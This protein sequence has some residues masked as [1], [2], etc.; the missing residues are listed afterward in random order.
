M[1]V[2]A[3]VWPCVLHLLELDFP[4]RITLGSPR[5]LS[6]ATGWRGGS[7]GTGL[8]ERVLAHVFGAA[9][10]LLLRAGRL[11]W[12]QV[13]LIPESARESVGKAFWADRGRFPLIGA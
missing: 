4:G 13:C 3:V 10:A 2:E 8:S 11:Q 12:P 9:A 1:Q 5:A 6:A 7:D